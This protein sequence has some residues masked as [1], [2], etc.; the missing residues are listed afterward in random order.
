MKTEQV[1]RWGY[2]GGGART[3]K[4]WRG[5]KEERKKEEEKGGNVGR[6]RASGPAEWTS[7]TWK[8]TQHTCMQCKQWS[9]KK[10]WSIVDRLAEENHAL[11]EEL[12][13]NEAYL[14]RMSSESKSLLAKLKKLIGETKQL[15]RMLKWSSPIQ[16]HRSLFLLFISETYLLTRRQRMWN[17]NTLFL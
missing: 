9:W 12:K 8:R 17:D 13:L 5:L 14:T 3:R 16:S 7:L 6:R 2:R 4:R 15:K 1:G 10:T 11:R